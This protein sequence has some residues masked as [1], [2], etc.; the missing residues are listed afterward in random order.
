MRFQYRVRVTAVIFKIGGTEK[1]MLKHLAVNKTN[2]R[3]KLCKAN[4]LYKSTLEAARK[5][6]K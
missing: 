2:R 6:K 3:N 5:L 4:T 1:Y